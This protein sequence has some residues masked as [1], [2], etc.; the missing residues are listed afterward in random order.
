MVSA[1]FVRVFRFNRY[2]FA[3]ESENMKVNGF[4]V[5]FKL[6]VLGALLGMKLGFFRNLYCSVMVVQEIVY[7]YF[8]YGDPRSKQQQGSAEKQFYGFL[9]FQIQH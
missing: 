1:G 7:V 9:L 3:D 6:A 4:V 8:R 2:Q 5:F